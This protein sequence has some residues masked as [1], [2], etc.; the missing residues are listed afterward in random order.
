MHACEYPLASD[1]SVL[2]YILYTFSLLHRFFCKK[3]IF[4]KY[5]LVI[6]CVIAGSFGMGSGQGGMQMSAAQQM[7]HQQL[8]RNQGL[9]GSPVNQM[10]MLSQQQSLGLQQSPPVPTAQGMANA[11]QVKYKKSVTCRQTIQTLGTWV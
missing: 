9:S 1:G 5:F 2:S 6:S 4:L 7:Q 3:K 8:V 10:Q 11:T